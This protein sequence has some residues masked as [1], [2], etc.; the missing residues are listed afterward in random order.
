MKFTFNCVIALI[1]VAV[2]APA[3]AQEGPF[4]VPTEE[5]CLPQAAQGIIIEFLEMNEEQVA[6]WDALIADR[7]AAAQPL[8]ESIIGI[9]TELEVLLSGDEPDP[10]VVGDLVIQR[11]DLKEELG[12]VYRDYVDGFEGLLLSEQLDR[13]HFIRRAEH[14]QPLFAPFR[15]MDLLPPHWR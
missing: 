6:Q 9:Q 14:A 13:Y 12:H 8:M 15:F 11:H 4:P 1:L 7:I 5:L 10:W 3:M 2:S